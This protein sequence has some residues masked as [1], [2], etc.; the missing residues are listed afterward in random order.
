M[1]SV[2]EGQGGT[3]HAG[4]FVTRESLANSFCVLRDPCARGWP[5]QAARKR[6][7]DAP[8][9]VIWRAPDGDNRLVEHELVALHRELVRARNEVDRVV[10]R[11]YLRYIRAE[12]EARAARRQAPAGD[13]Y[14]GVHP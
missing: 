6:G 8:V 11:E 12:E 2:L 1:S 9:A 7:T 10:V 3:A 13:I 14:G 5:E 4:N